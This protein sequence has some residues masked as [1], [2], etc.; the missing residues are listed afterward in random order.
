MFF[1]KHKLHNWLKEEEE[2][3]KGDH[4]SRSSIGSSSSK[5]KSSSREK[6]VEEKLRLAELIAEASFN[7]KKRSA[8]YQAQTLRMEEEL[9]K[10]RARAKVYDDMEGIDLGIGKNTEVYLPKKFEDNEVTL[11]NVPKG[12]VFEKTK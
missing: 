6:A 12:V 10:A 5:S 7:K 1:F 4:S 9:A 8:E 11:P 3:H 2:E